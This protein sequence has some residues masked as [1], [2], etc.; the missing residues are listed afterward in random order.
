[1]SM[2]QL[3]LLSVISAVYKTEEYFERCVNSLLD[4]DYKNL[5]IILVDD[6]SPDRCPQLCDEYEKKDSR[7]R[8]IH[9]ENGGSHSATNAGIEAARGKYIAICDNDDF[10]PKHAYCAMMERAIET[11]ADVVQGTLRRTYEDSGDSRLWERKESDSLCTKIIGMLAAIYKKDLIID[12]DIQL[13]PFKMGDDNGFRIQVFNHAKRVEYISDITYEYRM[14]AGDAQNPSAMQT[15]DFIHYYDDFRWRRWCL[16]YIV[17]S[18]KLMEMGKGN[19]GEFCMTIDER[20]LEYDKEQRNLC[21]AELQRINKCID[22]KKDKQSAKGYL[23]VDAEKF[24]DM[25]EEAYTKHLQF[26]FKIKRPIRK[27]LKR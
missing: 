22:W 1:M 6:G 15:K 2:E 5:E 11:D 18:E 7:I 20:W 3:P 19:L 21:F 24:A 16:E 4:S 25:S 9:K 14:R 17:M 8:V 23:Q 13:I 10:V 26:E 12:N 27:L